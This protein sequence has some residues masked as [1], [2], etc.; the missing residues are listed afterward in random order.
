MHSLVVSFASTALDG[1]ICRRHKKSGA[2]FFALFL[3]CFSLYFT[4]R[5]YLWHRSYYIISVRSPSTSFEA[6]RRCSLETP[7]HAEV[8]S[9]FIRL[10]VLSLGI[11]AFEFRPYH[12][13]RPSSPK[14]I[15]LC[16]LPSIWGEIGGNTLYKGVPSWASERDELL[17]EGD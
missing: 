4:P 12:H 8:S 13:Q 7:Q 14:D 2:V 6:Q 11:Y 9:H 3:S 16:V 1:T 5:V 15:W 17:P 10:A